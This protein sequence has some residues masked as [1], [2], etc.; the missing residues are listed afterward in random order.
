MAVVATGG[1]V[2]EGLVAGLLIPV[3]QAT[4][5]AILVQVA[6]DMCDPAWVVIPALG[7]LC[8][9]RWIVSTAV[10][11]LVSIVATA[12]TICLLLFNPCT[13]T[14]ANDERMSDNGRCQHI[15][16]LELWCPQ[17]IV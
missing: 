10:T 2:T 8:A 9:V 12:V 15:D 5:V 11:T 14:T 7:E 13:V 16:W 6:V 4:D 3:C 1:T 17:N